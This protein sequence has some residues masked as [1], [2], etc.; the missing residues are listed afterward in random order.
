MTDQQNTTTTTTADKDTFDLVDWLA[1][2]DVNDVTAR[3]S[4]TV[5]VYRN[6]ADIDVAVKAVADAE[7]TSRGGDQPIGGDTTDTVDQARERASA[8]MT[9]NRLGVT[10]YAMTEAETKAITDRY[11]T[12][13]TDWTYEALSHSARVDGQ[14]LTPTQWR[15]L[16]TAIGQGQFDRI[17]KAWFEAYTADAGVQ[18]DALFS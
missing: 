1:G 6:P 14:E 9:Q 16:H 11:D 7:K 4:R 18:V 8:L 15:A 17:Q 10:V 13:T 5:T 2:V 12:K 3:L